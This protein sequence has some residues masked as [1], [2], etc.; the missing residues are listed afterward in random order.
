MRT[1]FKMLTSFVSKHQSDWD[2]CIPFIMMA[3]RSSEH[4]TTEISPCQ[5]MFGRDINLPVDLVIG[6]PSN[7]LDNSNSQPDDHLT[8]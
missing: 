2:Q 3:Y 5:M 8:K 1:I 6:K 4:K 7:I